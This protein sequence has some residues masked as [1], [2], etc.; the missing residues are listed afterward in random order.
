MG[1]LKRLFGLEQIAANIEQAS[2][3]SIEQKLY[4]LELEKIAIQTAIG[5]IA[6]AVSQCEFRTFLNGKEVREEEYYRWNYSPNVNQNSSQF[7]WDWVETLIY[8]GDALI[9]EEQNQLFLADT[10]TT[11]ENGINERIFENISVD[12]QDLRSR[13]ARDALYVV[14]DNND[15]RPMLSRVCNEYEN[16]IEKA[17]E[18]YTK[19]YSE[20]GV[21]AMDANKR[22]KTEDEDLKME[23]IGKRFKKFFSAENAVLPLYGGQTYTPQ[24]KNLR[25]TSDINDVKILTDEIYNRVGQVFRIPP[26][27]LRGEIGDVDASTKNFLRYSVKPICFLLEREITRKLYGPKAMEKGSYLMIDTSRLEITGAFDMAEKVDKLI[28]CGLYSID[29]ARRKT[30][31]PEVGL[32]ETQK[33]FI[34]KNYAEIQQEGGNADE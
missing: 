24:T 32:P 8:D 33:H 22:G 15:I 6:S 27:L 30:G 16:L 1:V 11:N 25:N 21:L 9:I 26:T 17:V 31:E 7:I 4:A 14:F 10:Y 34:T 19:S 20:K 23:L 12:G 5:Y 28:A 18:G 13:P 3:Y 2:D 29:E